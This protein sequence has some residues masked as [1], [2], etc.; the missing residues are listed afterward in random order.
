MQEARELDL[1]H[2]CECAR[3]DDQRH[4]SHASLSL[5]IATRLIVTSTRSENRFY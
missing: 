5:G 3:V 2:F 1:Q 4:H